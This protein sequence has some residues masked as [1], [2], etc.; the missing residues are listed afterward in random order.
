MAIIKIQ[1][2]VN[3]GKD[4]EQWNLSAIGGNVNWYSHYGKQYGSFSSKFKNKATESSSNPTSRYISKRKSLSWVHC[5]IIHSSKVMEISY[6]SIDEWIK[7]MWGVCVC[8]WIPLSLKRRWKSCV[9]QQHEWTW[10][11]WNKQDTERQMLHYLT[12]MWKLK[13]SSS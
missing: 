5:S 13:Q 1:K 6:M 12:Y 3:V 9:L 7:K 4:V 10:R 11:K 8:I 2:I